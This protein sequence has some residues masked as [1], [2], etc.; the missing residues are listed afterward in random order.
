MLVRRR[1]DLVPLVEVEPCQHDVAAVRRGGGQRDAL[2]RHAHEPRDGRAEDPAEGED[3]LEPRRAAAPL[4][5]PAFLL[6][7]HRLARAARE[8][9]DGTRLQVREALQDGKA[10]TCGRERLRAHRRDSDNP[11]I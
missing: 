3:A 6:R 10:S 5:E 11:G 1:D 9:A 4:S 8:R 7:A 2:G